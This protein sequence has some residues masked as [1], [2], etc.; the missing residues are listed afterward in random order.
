MMMF[1]NGDV[2][3]DY[4]DPNITLIVAMKHFKT[5]SHGANK[6][7]RISN[8]IAEPSQEL[9]DS[10][11]YVRN[12]I[13]KMKDEKCNNNESIDSSLFVE[14]KSEVA[15]K[16]SDSSVP[17]AIEFAFK[18]YNN[19]ISAQECR[20]RAKEFTEY[21]KINTV[22]EFAL[23]FSILCFKT[24]GEVTGKRLIEEFQD[25]L[26]REGLSGLNRI[27]SVEPNI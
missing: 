13:L 1:M 11:E 12:L 24:Y 14:C 10:C 15:E 7:G 21:Y 3:Y 26:D 20:K 5:I 2:D 23:L 25:I 18:K 6:L 16:N 17:G 9:Q 4:D 8:V 27:I 19:A 22:T